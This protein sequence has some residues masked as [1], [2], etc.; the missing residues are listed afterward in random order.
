MAQQSPQ[1]KILSESKYGLKK[2]QSQYLAQIQQNFQ[3]V[4]TGYLITLATEQFSY[5]VTSQTQFEFDIENN[6]LTIREL[7]LPDQPKSAETTVK[8]SK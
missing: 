2:T 1:P 5:N 8:A 6:S 4:I 7:E 3:A